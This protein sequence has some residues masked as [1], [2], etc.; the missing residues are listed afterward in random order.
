MPPETK[1]RRREVGGVIVAV[2]L[3]VVELDPEPIGRAPLE[4]RLQGRA[5]EQAEARIG[6][7]VSNELPKL[8]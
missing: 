6:V 8:P 1:I 7:V 5:D 3:L 4:G 2:Q